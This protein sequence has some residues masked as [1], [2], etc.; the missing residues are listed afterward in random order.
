VSSPN[1]LRIHY[2]AV[3]DLRPHDNERDC[4]SDVVRLVRSWVKAKESAKDHEMDTLGRG[5]LSGHCD[6]QCKGSTVEVRSE[7]GRLEPGK[8]EFWALRYDEVCGEERHRRWR[9]DVALTRLDEVVR[10]AVRVS[11][12]LTPEFIGEEPERPT[13]TS[14]KV[15]KTI[16]QDRRWRASAGTQELKV[17]PTAIRVGHL[18][19]LVDGLA[20]TERTVP[21]IVVSAL[22]QTNE[23]PLSP[24]DLAWHAAGAASVFTL[25][26]DEDVIQEA[27]YYLPREYRCF[28]GLVRVF[29]PGVDLSSG[30]DWRRHRFFTPD[31]ISQSGPSAVLGMIYRGLARRPMAT[32][33]QCVLDVDDVAMRHMDHERGRLRQLL[34]GAADSDDLQAQKEWAEFLLEENA[35]AT[36]QASARASELDEV[37]RHLDDRDTE[38]LTEMQAHD[39][40]NSEYEYRLR[41]SD[42][43]L[44]RLEGEL[45]NT[46]A[47]VAVLAKLDTF[48]G[49]LVAVLRLVQDLYPSSVV[50]LDDAFSSADGWPFDVDRAWR[51]LRSMAVYLPR[52]HF[53]ETGV[54]IEKEF[55]SATGFKLA[56]TETKL[57]K[58]DKR[59]AAQRQRVLDGNTIDITPHV[60]VGSSKPNMLRVHYY[61]EHEHKR[62]VIGHCGDHL[63]TAGTRRRK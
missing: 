3:F 52:L 23:E 27:N 13:A 16:L 25:P 30:S 58:E 41:F 9:T 35:R 6:W 22:R 12:Y 15:V 21:I 45:A 49:D 33:R 57:T 24:T 18:P 40:D 60:K 55:E 10:V 56:M 37:R 44:R 48:P 59:A 17:A 61:A 11:H 20:D 36:S 1:D 34:E 50:V 31:Y 51:V 62:I 47:A 7:P 14:P 32:Q 4:A 29:M 19:T 42:E 39:D 46:Q 28:N 63:D 8:P 53:E 26:A 43:R 2:Q 38:L 54:D 5:W